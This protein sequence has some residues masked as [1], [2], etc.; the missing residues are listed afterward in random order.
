MFLL[1]FK[2]FMQCS[3]SFQSW[4]VKRNRKKRYFLSFWEVFWQPDSLFMPYRTVQIQ[5][6]Y[7]ECS[8]SSTKLKYRHR[9]WLL[10]LFF[11]ISSP[12]KSRNAILQFDSRAISHFICWHFLA[13]RRQKEEEKET[14]HICL[15][16]IK[17]YC[18]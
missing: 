17:S 15:K 12:R 14:C 3:S 5:L 16:A 8:T 6:I 13:F 7:Y 11:S 2:S 4:Q 9:L 1:I 18:I 10:W